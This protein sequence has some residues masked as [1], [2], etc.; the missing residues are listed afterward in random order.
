MTAKYLRTRLFHALSLQTS[1]TT[2]CQATE[3]RFQVRNGRHPSEQLETDLP[4]SEIDEASSKGK[5][6]APD[7]RAEGKRPHNNLSIRLILLFHQV[8]ADTSMGENGYTGEH[9]THVAEYL[10]SGG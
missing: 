2:S 9:S 10:G 1:L 4:S 6:Q 3:L 5:Q 7:P 8:S